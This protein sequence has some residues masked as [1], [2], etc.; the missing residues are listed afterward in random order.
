M[1]GDI[2]SGGLKL[3]GGFMDSQRQDENAERNIALQREF[4][5]N[6][7]Q[8]KAADALKAGISPVYAMG[9]PTTSF[10]PISLGGGSSLGSALGSMGQD[11]SRA[12][13]S[14]S[15]SQQ[16]VGQVS[17]L[18]EKLTVE[19][20]SLQNDLLRSQIARLN[21]STAPTP[22]LVGPPPNSMDGL[23][24]G[25]VKVDPSKTEATAPGAP[26]QAAAVVPD[27]S[28]SQTATGL[29]PVPSKSVKDLVEDIT[30]PQLM[31]GIRNNLLPNFTGGDPPSQSPGVGKIWVFDP[32]GQEYRAVPVDSWQA[33]AFGRWFGRS[34][35]N[36][37][38]GGW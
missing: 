33:K 6:S 22:P 32:R 31:W 11:V 4:A 21:Q 26:S 23:R 34:R 17:Q 9:A 30:I 38:G 19:R 8:W 28:F 36:G 29:A 37:S 25:S 27:V 13:A 12:V 35:G 24:A 7:I 14:G 3:L 5:Q 16:R 1:L 15:D 10:S 2:I 20:A 18:M